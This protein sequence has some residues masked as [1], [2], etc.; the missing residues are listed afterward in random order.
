[1]KGRETRKK[2]YADIGWLQRTERILEIIRGRIRS[3][4]VENWM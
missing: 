3:L 1:M 2:T 4:S